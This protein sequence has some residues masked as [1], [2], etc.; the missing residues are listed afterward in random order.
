MVVLSSKC[1]EGEGAIKALLALCN[2][3]TID[4]AIGE[5]VLRWHVP[6]VRKFSQQGCGSAVEIVLFWFGEY[7][8]INRDKSSA[9]RHP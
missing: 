7:I 1:Q 5:E 3:D 2:T 8:F 6:P 9:T 4:L